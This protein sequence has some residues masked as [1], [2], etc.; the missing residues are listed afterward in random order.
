[1]LNLLRNGYRLPR[2]MGPGGLTEILL[3][4]VFFCL[5]FLGYRHYVADASPADFFAYL[6]D[7][8]KVA[9]LPSIDDNLTFQYCAGMAFLGGW[10]SIWFGMVKCA[11]ELFERCVLVQLVALF[12]L[13]VPAGLILFFWHTTWL[14]RVVLLLW[15]LIM[16]VF[17]VFCLALEETYWICD[18][19]ARRRNM[20]E[21][22]E[23][24]LAHHRN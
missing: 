21:Q 14:I 23:D 15:Y 19:V 7:P 10:T 6:L 24:A 9:V 2:P 16:L 4:L 12:L 3:G 8:A 1:M 22:Q 17:L 11:L 13:L 18:K 20:E 5:A